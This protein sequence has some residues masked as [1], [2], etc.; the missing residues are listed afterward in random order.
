MHEGDDLWI[1]ESALNDLHAHH[2]AVRL[3]GADELDPAQLRILGEHLFL[4]E[5]R[6]SFGGGSDV[7]EGASQCGRVLVEFDGLRRSRHREFH[8]RNARIWLT[9][10]G[11]R[12]VDC[13][14]RAEFEDGSFAETITQGLVRLSSGAEECDRERKGDLSGSARGR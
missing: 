6:H 10:Y 11:P 4:H 8:G 13:H 2:L 12:R 3:D 14:V 1:H 5:L 9:V 7:G